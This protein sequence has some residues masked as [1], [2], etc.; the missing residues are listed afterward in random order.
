MIA[1]IVRSPF[2]FSLGFGNSW[3]V[4]AHRTLWINETKEAT[5]KIKIRTA[6]YWG[7]EQNFK[8]GHEK[9]TG[10]S[11]FFKTRWQGRRIYNTNGLNC[12]SPERGFIIY[13]FYVLFFHYLPKIFQF[14]N[15]QFF[16]QYN[17]NSIFVIL[18]SIGDW[19][20]RTGCGRWRSW[21]CHL[22]WNGVIV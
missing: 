15:G 10:K 2:G 21:R 6:D 22:S 9:L 8:L 5:F 11:F 19:N 4:E 20:G 16:V 7:R 17:G 18:T 3:S 12:W 13:F 14:S 1:G